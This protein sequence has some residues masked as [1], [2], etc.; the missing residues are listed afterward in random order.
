MGA[1]TIKAMKSWG[2]S[3]LTVGVVMLAYAQAAEPRQWPVELSVGRF[4][5]HADFELDQRQLLVSELESMR[6]DLPATLNI[7]ASSHPVH[8][9]LFE[10]PNEYHRYMQN[11]FPQLPTRRAIFIQDRGPG[12]LFTHWHADIAN[13]LRHEITH[14][15]LNDHAQPLPLWLDEGLAEY[16]EVPGPQRFDGCEYLPQVIERAEQGFIPSLKRLE[17]IASLDRFSNANYRD[18]WSW[19]HFLIHR[20]TATR[21]LLSEF[22]NQHRAGMQPLSLAR[23]LSQTIPDAN[24]EYREH[25]LALQTQ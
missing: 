2:G 5:I 4:E 25:F 14:A 18:S 9:V 16:F 20:S 3:L 12:M 6:D 1:F 22:I 21:E 7:V 15:I 8:V 19:I 17:E 10:S 11:Y 23:Q 13:D 24:A